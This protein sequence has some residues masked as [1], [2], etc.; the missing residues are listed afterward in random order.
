[1]FLRVFLFMCMEDF[2]SYDLLLPFFENISGSY[3]E[4]I[5]SDVKYQKSI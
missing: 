1:M 2:K 5:F 4:V 3:F